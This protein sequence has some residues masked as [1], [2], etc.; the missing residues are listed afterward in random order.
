MNRDALVKMVVS[1]TS[2]GLVAGALVI[3]T[4]SDGPSAVQ[5]MHHRAVASEH[6]TA[7]AA[8]RDRS[9]AAEGDAVLPVSLDRTAFA[10]FVACLLAL[11]AWAAWQTHHRCE[12]CGYCPIWCRCDDLAHRH[13]E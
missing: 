12:T 3:G 5:S 8:G 11:A 1:L 13:G 4:F 9:G 2:I 7:L 6:H 10:A